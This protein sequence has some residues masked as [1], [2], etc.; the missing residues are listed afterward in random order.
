MPISINIIACLE[1]SCHIWVPQLVYFLL[2]I[3]FFFFSICMCI[4]NCCQLWPGLSVAQ[5]IRSWKYKSFVSKLIAKFNKCHRAISSLP[6]NNNG[7][8]T[9]FLWRHAWID[10]G[11]V[12]GWQVKGWVTSYGHLFQVAIKLFN[13]TMYFGFYLWF[14]NN[15]Q[16]TSQVQCSTMSHSIQWDEKSGTCQYL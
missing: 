3:W 10:E 8:C 5:W 2:L 9:G 16:N 12:K 7:P 13:G 14:L 11:E 15:Q 6:Y 4:S 1:C